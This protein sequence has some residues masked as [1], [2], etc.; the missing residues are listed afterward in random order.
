MDE[1]NL[2]IRKAQDMF[3]NKIIVELFPLNP[4]LN[5][6]SVKFDLSKFWEDIIQFDK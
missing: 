4:I 1:K 5:G 6:I 2:S 3:D